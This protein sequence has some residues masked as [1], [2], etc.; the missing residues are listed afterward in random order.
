M[1]GADCSRSKNEDLSGSKVV[2]A[3]FAIRA[4]KFVAVLL[5]CTI[6][7]TFL[8]EQLVADTLYNC[9]DL[10]W[11]DYLFPGDWVHKPVSVRHATAGRSMSEPDITLASFLHG[12]RQHLQKVIT[13]C[14]ASNIRGS[15]SC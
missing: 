10:G 9:T 14:V 3:R 6:A 1:N 2:M 15:F 11:L 8:W 4:A 13:P 5:C 7:F 12:V